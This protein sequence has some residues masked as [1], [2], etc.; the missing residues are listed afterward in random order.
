MK[1]INPVI[2]SVLTQRANILNNIK[3]AE[4]SIEKDKN[5]ISEIDD[6]FGSNPDFKRY[7][8]ISLLD[9][10]GLL[11]ATIDYLSGVHDKLKTYTEGNDDRI[12]HLSD[13]INH[14]RHIEVNYSDPLVYGQNAWSACLQ[15]LGYLDV[16]T[17]ERID[18]DVWVHRALQ[19]TLIRTNSMDAMKAQMRNADVLTPSTRQGVNFNSRGGVVMGN[20]TSTYNAMMNGGPMYNTPGNW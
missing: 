8:E 18:A 7:V 12:R 14:L 15:H 4:L 10:H 20:G 6:Y 11:K 16:T 2:L 3:M 13:F 5:S 17:L 9:G 19:E 1:S